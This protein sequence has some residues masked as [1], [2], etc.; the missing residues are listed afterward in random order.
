MPIVH[1]TVY[2]MKHPVFHAAH[3]KQANPN[4]TSSKSS[5]TEKLLQQDANQKGEKCKIIREGLKSGA[6]TLVTE[7]LIKI[8]LPKAEMHTGHAFGEV[9]NPR[10]YKKQIRT[11]GSCQT[12]QR[13]QPLEKSAGTME[14]LDA[15]VINRINML[16][17]Q[18]AKSIPLI[19]ENLKKFD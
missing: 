12:V 2:L 8:S 11:K 7:L 1:E 16:V 13:A 10:L 18:G 14:Q 3:F 6:S 9:I 15:A 17:A 5:D 19:K 4:Q